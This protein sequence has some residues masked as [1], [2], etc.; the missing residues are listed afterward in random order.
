MGLTFCTIP[1]LSI[2]HGLGGGGTRPAGASHAP[3]RLKFASS[4][5]PHGRRIMP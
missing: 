3:N 1:L 5:L 4:N 2:P